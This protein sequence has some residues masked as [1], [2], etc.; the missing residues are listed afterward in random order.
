MHACMHACIHTCIHT[1][2][3]ILYVDLQDEIKLMK[4]RKSESCTRC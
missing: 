2:I 1:Y 4:S 3:H